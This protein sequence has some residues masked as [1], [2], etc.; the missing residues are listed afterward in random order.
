MRNTTD[1][2]ATISKL[3]GEAPDVAAARLG[4][5]ADKTPWTIDHV[6]FMELTRLHAWAEASVS[7]EQWLEGEGMP[8]DLKASLSELQ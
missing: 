8:P 4:D 2:I 3:T 7:L 6:A 1:I 5:V